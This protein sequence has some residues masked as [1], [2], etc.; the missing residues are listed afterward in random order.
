MAHIQFVNSKFLFKFVS[1]KLRLQNNATN[2]RIYFKIIT[3][4]YKKA[5]FFLK[6]AVTLGFKV[7]VGLGVRY[8][9]N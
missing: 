8:V 1:W 5:A 2:V 7:H 9:D 4:F 6:L 3:S